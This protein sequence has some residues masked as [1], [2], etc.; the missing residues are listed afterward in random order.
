M[1]CE[2]KLTGTC[3]SELDTEIRFN[4][5][6]SRQEKAELIRFSLSYDVISAETKRICNCVVK[7]LRSMMKVN[8]IQFFI[9]E[10]DIHSSSTEAEFLLNKYSSFILSR[11]ST[12]ISFLIKL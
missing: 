7:I 4:V 9:N 8:L 2:Y 1:F 5:A 6:N 12:D 10:E 3:L 11:Q